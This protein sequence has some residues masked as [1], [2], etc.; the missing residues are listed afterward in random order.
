VKLRGYCRVHHTPYGIYDKC[1]NLSSMVEVSM[2][3]DDNDLVELFS[4]DLD[5]DGVAD[6]SL[7]IHHKVLAVVLALVAS[8]ATWWL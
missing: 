8:I 4:V 6:V 5:G 7:R 2:Q 1:H 3:T